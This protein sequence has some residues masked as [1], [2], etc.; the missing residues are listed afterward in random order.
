MNLYNQEELD[1]I[2]KI[3]ETNDKLEDFF[4]DKRAEW[5]KNVEPLF[6]VLTTDL[7]N[8]SN[9]KDILEAQSISLSFKQAI[10]ENIN[11]F[12]NKRSRETTKIKKLR[13]D[14]FIFYATSFGVKTNM[15]EK[16]ILIDAHIAE[17]DRCLE[18]IES[19][20]TFLRDT[21]KNLES[22]GYAIKNMTELLNYLGR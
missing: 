1:R 21:V 20:I 13:Q 2:Q 9:F 5:N 19:Y 7:S 10:N 16:T 8:P 18:L 6:K 15:G 22:F 14:K 12:L 17:N 3:K 4:N 11:Y